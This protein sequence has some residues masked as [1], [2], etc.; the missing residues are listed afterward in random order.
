MFTFNLEAYFERQKNLLLKTDVYKLGH[1]RQYRP[2]TTKVYSGL[3]ARSSKN[4]SEHVF[5]GLQF[6]MLR[7]LSLPI[8]P[9][10]AEPFFRMYKHIL[11]TEVPDDVREKITALCALG[12]LPIEI[13][14]VKEGSVVPAKNVL[15]T[16]TNTHP[17]FYWVVGFIESLLLKI[18]YP[19][20]VATT[21]RAAGRRKNNT[22]HSGYF[23]AR[24]SHAMSAG[25]GNSSSSHSTVTGEW[26]TMS[27]SSQ[28]RTSQGS[29]DAAPSAAILCE[30]RTAS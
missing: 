5:D 3:V 23:L 17:D 18:W 12:Y 6:M 15:L 19:M 10:H 20:V 24:S 22:P 14:A 26:V 7:W 2:G 29:S 21:S 11:K 1:M 28:I 8:K 27:A 30:K 4:F 9:E 16:I 25:G 13:R